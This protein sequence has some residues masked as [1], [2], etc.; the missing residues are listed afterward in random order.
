MQTNKITPVVW[1]DM[2]E[3][4]RVIRKSDL[5]RIMDR[6]LKEDHLEGVKFK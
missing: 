3:M 4:S 5:Q 2:K 6:V 1:S